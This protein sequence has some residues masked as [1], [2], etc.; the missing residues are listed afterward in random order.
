MKFELFVC[1]FVWMSFLGWDFEG[2]LGRCDGFI[3]NVTL[4]RGTFKTR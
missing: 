2:F 4:S 3:R 1:L